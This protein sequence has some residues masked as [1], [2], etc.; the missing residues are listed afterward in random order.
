MLALLS[1]RASQ[2]SGTHIPSTAREPAPDP[3]QASYSPAL[4]PLG[5]AQGHPLRPGRVGKLV[6]WDD[7]AQAW[8]QCP[9]AP[10]RTGFVTSVVPSPQWAR[11]SIC[12]LPPRVLTRTPGDVLWGPTYLSAFGQKLIFS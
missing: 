7:P 3:R 10:L 11:I 12:P 4:G 2:V 1:Y 5:P 8:A 6:W 9:G